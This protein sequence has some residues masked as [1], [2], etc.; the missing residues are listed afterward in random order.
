M[1]VLI[2]GGCGFIGCNA[3]QRFLQEGYSVTILDNLSRR[4][5][6]QNL[7]WLRTQGEFEFINA[8]IREAE[9]VNETVDKGLL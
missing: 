8:D 5:S 4:G 6:E 2:T 1:K 7:A 3:A 9:K